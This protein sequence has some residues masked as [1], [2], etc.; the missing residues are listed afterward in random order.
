MEI[1]AGDGGAGGAWL[2][3]GPAPAAAPA[4]AAADTAGA[5][6]A[7]ALLGGLVAA[8]LQ[9][10]ATSPATTTRAHRRVT[11]LAGAGRAMITS[12]ADHRILTASYGATNS[13]SAAFAALQERE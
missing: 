1:V 3:A 11:E 9:A 2:A 8:G 12:L 7:A 6:G 4:G 5:A 10:S 13:W